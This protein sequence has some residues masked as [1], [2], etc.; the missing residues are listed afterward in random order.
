MD[1][2]QN[3]LVSIKK[4]VFKVFI[5]D[6]ICICS[7]IMFLQAGMYIAAIRKMI[8]DQVKNGYSC[9]HSL[10]FCFWTQCPFYFRFMAHLSQ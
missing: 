2:S 9:Y 10:V 4:I 5:I 1:L 8:I 6:L 3:L 7:K